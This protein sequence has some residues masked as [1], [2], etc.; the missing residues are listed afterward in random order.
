LQKLKIANNRE[1]AKIQDA[2]SLSQPFLF[3]PH[4]VGE[5]QFQ[6]A[7]CGDLSGRP[8]YRENSVSDPQPSAN[9]LIRFRH[10]HSL[11]EDETMTITRRQAI[12]WIAST[13]PAAASAPAFSLSIQAAAAR[14]AIPSPTTARFTA[15]K[16]TFD[17]V[18]SE[19]RISM[20]ELGLESPADLSS[21]SHL[22]M[23][24]RLSSPQRM[25][26]WANTIH[27]PRS[28]GFIAFG[29]NAWLRASVPLR[30]FVAQDSSGFDLAS[31][32]NR[33]TSSCWFSVWGPFG[34]LESVE[35]IAIS[36]EYPLNRPSIEVRNVHLSKT[37]E[38]SEFLEPG[39]LLD[40]FGQWA[41]A[42]WPRKLH[43][44]E[45][46]I[47]ELAEEDKAL[48]APCAFGYARYGGYKNTQA[49]ATGFFRVEQIENQ[50]WFIDPE[51]HLFLSMGINGTPGGGAGFGSGPGS[52]RTNRRLDAW[53][54]TTGGQQRPG[55]IMLRWPRGINYLG[56]PDV[57]SPHYVADIDV[58]AN[59]QCAPHKNDP[60]L[61]GYFIGNE[62][63]W[64]GRESELCTLILAGPDTA[65][66]SALKDFLSRGDTP[67]LRREFV[68]ASFR[69]YLQIVCAAVRK[70]DPNHLILG[71]RFGGR[72]ADEVM[73][74][75]QIFDVCSINV[76][77]YEPTR[78]IIRSARLS[79]RP[80]LIGEFHIGVPADGLAAG[81][82]Q[83]K[84]QAERG[85][86]YRYYVEQAASLPWFVGAYWFEWRDEPVRGRMD[87]ENYNIGFVDVT[88]R[89]YAELVEAAKTTHHCLQDIHSGKLL[90]FARHPLASEAGAPS[91]PWP[92]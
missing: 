63:P 15:R 45:Q 19:L 68:L 41:L 86:A 92:V 50:W 22:V 13:V 30:F 72:M 5:I 46:L 18:Y 3:N 34:D 4:R 35:S 91:T 36:M 6:R 73:I 20:S 47:R 43:N 9:C 88:D 61:L 10:P 26:L 29:Q 52:E 76:Y 71:I 16:F 74:A 14:S 39:P 82:V 11:P 90:P 81:L 28:M 59:S 77:E 51:G 80:I 8:G 75:A 49:R 23:E 2:Q 64:N 33:R 12:Q 66:R 37:D 38:G 56:L 84:D 78:Q 53:G 27:G 83:A 32:A 79:G 70:Y 42:D 89:P 58:A 48:A 24:M 40:S 60:L 7:G 62:P 44:Q 57:Y 17:G 31:A 67:V 1:F 87:G 55:T 54:F 85:I 65:T 25:S 69:K 21:Y